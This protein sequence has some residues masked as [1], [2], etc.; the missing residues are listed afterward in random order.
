MRILITGANGFVGAAL[1]RHLSTRGDEV[2]CLVRDGSDDSALSGVTFTRVSGDVTRPRTLAAAVD[3]VDVVY[4]LAGTRRGSTRDDFM[5]V[6][7]EGTRFVAEAMVAT[8]ARR[9]V[10]VGS[11]AASGPSRSGHPRV[12]TQ[13]LAPTEWY[14]ESKAEAER[15]AFGFSSQLDVTCCRPSRILGPGDRENLVFFRLAKRGLVLKLG[16]PPRRISMVDV[17]DAVDQLVLQGTRPEAVGETFFC[18]SHE[19]LTLDGLMQQAADV[20]GVSARTVTVPEAVLP[21]LGALADVASNVSG[22]KLPLSRKLARQLLAPGW[23]CSIEKAQR[24]LGYRPRR[25]VADAL[26]RSAESYVH[27]GW[28]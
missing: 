2:R 27:L 6:N 5:R 17:D 14:G 26:K 22:R 4:H 3:G 19:S 16:G 8:K 9:L 20:L 23:E 24:L 10:L 13:P 18:S 11:L 15:I 28:L 21:G 12:E 1:A 7:A 25:A